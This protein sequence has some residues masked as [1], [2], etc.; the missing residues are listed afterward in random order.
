MQLH[1]LAPLEKN[2]LTPLLREKFLLGTIFP[3]V[4]YLKYQ[5]K[6][7]KLLLKLLKECGNRKKCSHSLN[8]PSL[9]QVKMVLPR[10]RLEKVKAKIR[11]AKEVTRE[12][13]VAKNALREMVAKGALRETMEKRLNLLK[14][15]LNLL[16]NRKFKEV[17]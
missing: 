10:K 6:S 7:R 13:M 5:K 15:R 12:A 9:K 8:Q 3:L 11:M 1:L 16:K 14:K 4:F 2:Q 17:P